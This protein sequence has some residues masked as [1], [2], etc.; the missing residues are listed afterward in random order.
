MEKNQFNYAGS[1]DTFTIHSVLRFVCELSALSVEEVVGRKRDR[2]YVRPRMIVA[3]FARAEGYTLTQIGTVLN[4][5]FSTIRNL[6][7]KALDW[8]G[9]DKLFDRLFDRMAEAVRFGEIYTPT[10]K[11]K[12]SVVQEPV[13]EPDADRKHRNN[14]TAASRALLTAV[15]LAA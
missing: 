3:H 6:E 1:R 7:Q 13:D 9:R 14:M 8:R 2:L 11:V 4:R 12:L 15:R 5:D 10:V